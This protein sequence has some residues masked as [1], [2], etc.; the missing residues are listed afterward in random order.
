MGLSLPYLEKLLA[1]AVPMGAAILLTRLWH[2][3]LLNRY[4]FLALSLLCE[5]STLGL[6]AIPRRTTAYFYV[7]TIIEI[8]SSIVFILL[9]REVFVLVVQDYRGIARSGR[10]FIGR[11][12]TLA[13]LGSL[14]F[15]LFYPQTGPGHFSALERSFLVFRVIAFTLMAFL[16]LLMIFVLWFPIPLKRNVLLLASGYSCYLT[17]RALSRFAANLFGPDRYVLLGTIPTGRTG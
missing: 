14:L 15:A 6:R 5:I 8:L 9:V 7:W 3:Q 11:A 16:V 4:R 2:E 12:I 1:F 13:V 17:S 10:A